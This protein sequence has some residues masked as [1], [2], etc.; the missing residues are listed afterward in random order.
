MC[1]SFH[2]RCL[3]GPKDA[4]D[5]LVHAASF[6]TDLTVS[7]L[8]ASMEGQRLS[9]QDWALLVKFQNR[10]VPTLGPHLNHTGYAEAMLSTASSVRLL[11]G[12]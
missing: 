9:S 2:V 8:T 3:Y 7:P 4:E 1:R 11:S 10:T 5:A 6:V 12:R